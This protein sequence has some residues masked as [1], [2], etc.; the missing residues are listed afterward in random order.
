MSCHHGVRVVEAAPLVQVDVNAQFEMEF[1]GRMKDLVSL[2][3][4]ADS[5][6]RRECLNAMAFE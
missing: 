6:H 1:P 3:H 4:K 2:I 5:R